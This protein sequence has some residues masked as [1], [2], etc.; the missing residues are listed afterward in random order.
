MIYVKGFFK[1][2]SRTK[3]PFTTRE[4]SP[5]VKIT[6]HA[7]LTQSTE[8]LTFMIAVKEPTNVRVIL[9]SS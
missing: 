1:D 4:F 8:N 7:S 3:T 5:V 9:I 6:T 2:Y